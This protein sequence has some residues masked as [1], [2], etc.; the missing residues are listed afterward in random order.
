M[1]N[2][3]EI[4]A[5]VAR[6]A[7]DPERRIDG[8]PLYDLPSPLDDPGFLVA[9]EDE[10]G[11]A[12]PGLLKA[13]FLQVGDGGFGPGYG[14]FGARSGHYLSDEPFTLAELYRGALYARRLD[15]TPR[16]W[17][18]GMLPICEWGCDFRGCIDCT[19]ED[20]PVFLSESDARPVAFHPQHL[21]FRDWIEAWADGVDVTPK[22]G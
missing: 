18:E 14:L 9:L 8:E 13:L 20:Y 7:A 15:G 19:D 3:T 2:D 22:W 11:F 5:K 17:R 1:S 21:S 16:G 4:L 12:L 6:R 10:L